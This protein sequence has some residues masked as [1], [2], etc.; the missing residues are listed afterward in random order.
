[1]ATEHSFMVKSIPERTEAKKTRKHHCQRA[2]VHVHAHLTA[3]RAN[4][5]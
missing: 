2:H 4:L 5:I 1:M 3:V